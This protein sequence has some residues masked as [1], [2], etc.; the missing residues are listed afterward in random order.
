MNLGSRSS[1]T[2][3]MRDGLGCEVVAAAA[4]TAEK[5]RR[6][7]GV[8]K[9]KVPRRRKRERDDIVIRCVQGFSLFGSECSFVS[10]SVRG[11]ALILQIRFGNVLNHF[12]VLFKTN[13]K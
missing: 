11:T 8:L 9:L 13:R 3:V 6:F 12:F 4:V 1:F 10:D 5:K 7:V 2:R